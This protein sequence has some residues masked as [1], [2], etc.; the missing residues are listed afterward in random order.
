MSIAVIIT[1]IIAF[2]NMILD[3]VNRITISYS[4][5]SERMA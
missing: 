3:T 5:R 1:I 2:A 4:H